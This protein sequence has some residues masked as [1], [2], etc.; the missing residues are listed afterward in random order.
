[1]KCVIVSP[2]KTV[3]DVETDFVVLPLSDGECGILAGHSP[4]IARLGAG[5]LR[6]QNK[7]DKTVYY[8]E[9]GF[10]EVLDDT[11]AVLTMNALPIAE[12]NVEDVEEQLNE[13]MELPSNTPEAT[14]YRTQVIADHTAKLRTAKKYAKV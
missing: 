6:I 11:V 8:V 10:V 7:N 12:L 9:G 14:E 4:L 1:M 5:D 3:L 13:A 2:E